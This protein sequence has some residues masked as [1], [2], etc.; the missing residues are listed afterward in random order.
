M[1][2]PIS[3]SALN[4]VLGFSCIENY[5]LSTLS[6]YSY[7][8]FNSFVCVSEIIKETIIGGI[9]FA[10]LR[11]IPRIQHTAELE[12]F[13]HYKSWIAKDILEV[14]LPDSYTCVEVRPEW[15]KG[16]YRERAWR[17]DHYVMIERRSGQE[18]FIVNDTPLDEIIVS[19]DEAYT[20]FAGGVF[21]YSVQEVDILEKKKHY[22]ERFYTNLLQEEAPVSDLPSE[23]SLVRFRDFL[24]IMKISRRRIAQFCS[25][26]FDTG[27]LT[28]YLSYLDKCFIGIE[29]MRLRNRQDNKIILEMLQSVITQDIE[30]KYM[31]KTLMEG[32]EHECK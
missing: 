7:L 2:L 30:T 13:I 5:V 25:N 14:F 11:S 1:V 4:S 19:Y 32:M 18:I 26:Y 10:N 8:Y 28:E 16:R 27:F 12:G 3:K 15:F 31:I 9:G 23:I 24:G 22:L 20:L 29:Y 21:S 6:H 17:D